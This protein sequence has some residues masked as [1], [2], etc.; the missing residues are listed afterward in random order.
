MNNKVN[1]SDIARSEGVSRQAIWRRTKKGKAYQ[2]AYQLTDKYKAYQKHV[3]HLKVD[4][5]FKNC[6][7]CYEQN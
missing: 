6:D 7:K 2:K 4:K 1:L 5:L 3:Y